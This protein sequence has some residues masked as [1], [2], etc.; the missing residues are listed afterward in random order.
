MNFLRRDS[1]SS[2]QMNVGLLQIPYVLY[3]SYK[4]AQLIFMW[5]HMSQ[6][7]NTFYIYNIQLNIFLP[8]TTT[9]AKSL[10]LSGFTTTVN[11]AFLKSELNEH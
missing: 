6:H 11:W 2:N 4:S 8:S 9:S 3:G 10:F 7:K 1:C 5:S